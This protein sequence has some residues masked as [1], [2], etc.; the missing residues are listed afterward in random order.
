MKRFGSVV[1][2]V[3]VSALHAEA[4][5]VGNR[6]RI[7]GFG[8]LEFEKQFQ[9]LGFG[10]SRGSFDIDVLGFAVN[11]YLNDRTRI[12]LETDWVHGS[13][14]NR[15]SVT[16]EYGF[17]EYTAKEGL[18]LR[19]GKFLTPFG[20]Y[21]EIH[22]IA[23]SFEAVKLPS[24]PSLASRVLRGGYRP[25]PRSGVGLA[26]HGDLHTGDK[27]LDFDVMIG[28]G[29]QTNTNPFEFD[30]NSSKSVTARI[31]FEANDSLRIGNSFYYDRITEKGFNRQISDGLEAEYNHKAIRLQSEIVFSHKR[32]DDGTQMKQFGWYLFGSYRLKNRLAPY[33]RYEY[34]TFRE[35]DD[36]HGRN[37]ITGL[38]YEVNKNL[39]L[40]IENNFLHG[41]AKSG[42]N[43]LPGR[44]YSQLQT[45]LSFGF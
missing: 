32:R 29:E 12:S 35:Q 38:N 9:S 5:D 1:L 27:D 21:N 28:N 10:D 44:G 3:A 17:V 13:D 37:I 15:G 36:N 45:A 31:R 18:K 30:D 22:N 41:S 33:I 14:L 26:A 11:A 20:I 24:P 23:Y 40:K 7:N 39:Y 43:T 25:Y 19:G 42:F 34:V 2:L 6:I 8:S 4:Q 16:L